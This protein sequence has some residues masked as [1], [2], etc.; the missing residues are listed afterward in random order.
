MGAVLGKMGHLLESIEDEWGDTIPHI[1]SLVVNKTGSLRGLP[2]EGIKEFWSN[3]PELTKV[4]KTHKARA[5]YVKIRDFGSRWN[6]V[7]TLLGI[8]QIEASS[9]ETAQKGTGGYGKGGESEQHFALKTF[10]AANPDLVG[11]KIGDEAY[12]EYVL[13]S[14]DTIDVLFKGSH[15]WTAV[16]V[17]SQ[18]SDHLPSDY[19]RGLYQCVK[20]RAILEA[21]RVDGHYRVPTEIEVVLVLQT[22]LPKDYRELAKSLQVRVL[23]KVIP[24]T[25]LT[26]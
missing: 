17:K 11:A 4:E 8:P 12:T 5:E 21:M 25:T 15:C 7:L 3:Y 13:P 2:D 20:Y 24:R 26:P 22:K 10:I 1:Q 14:L 16:E 18:I 9:A 23:E 19:E 6:K